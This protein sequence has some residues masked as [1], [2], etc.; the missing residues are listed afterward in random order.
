MKRGPRPRPC[1]WGRRYLLRVV[2]SGS[3]SYVARSHRHI[4]LG[5]PSGA[6]FEQR[7]AVLDSWYREE[8]RGAASALIDRRQQQLG[9]ELRRF[10][11]QRMKKKWGGSS[12][13]RGTIRLN[14]EL[15]KKDI[16]CLD[17]VILHELAHFIVPDHGEGFIALLDHHMPNWR[18]IRK[19]LNDLP[20]PAEG[21]EE[22]MRG[23][24]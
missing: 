12:P 16:E 6:D 20:L 1:T 11:I 13:Q 4:E 7:R 14:L 19:H 3:R 5:I 8:L 21:G 24:V 17:Y 15:A 10:F 23:A 9:V 18:H 2:E 22:T